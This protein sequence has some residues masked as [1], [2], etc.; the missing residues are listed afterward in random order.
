LE[1]H[2]GYLCRWEDFDSEK[3]VEI[4][5]A[6]IIED[7]Q[8]PADCS[9]LVSVLPRARV[10]R[11]A[12]DGAHTYGR[13]G[14]RWYE[15]HHAMAR[16]VSRELGVTVHAYVF[17]PD[18]LEQVVAYGGG[19]KVGGE[20][21]KYEDAELDE[22][23]LDDSS[24]EKMKEKWPLGHIARVLGVAREELVRIPRARTVLLSLDGADARG[25]LSELFPGERVRS[26]RG[27]A[28]EARALAVNEG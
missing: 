15:Q 22:D 28:E 27:E 9:L 5:R 4:A 2:G 3:L 18:D 10:V 14:A 13:K 26:F 24:F 7:G 8:R 17:D 11:F 6:A 16:A 23:E 19:R 12:F 25:K 20:R 21:V 1:A